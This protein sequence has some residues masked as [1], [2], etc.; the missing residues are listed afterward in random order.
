MDALKQLPIGPAIL[1]G[2]RFVVANGPCLRVLKL[3]DDGKDLVEIQ[4]SSTLVQGGNITS[5]SLMDDGIKAY[6]LIGGDNRMFI[7]ADA[8][9]CT[10]VETFYVKVKYTG[11]LV[12]KAVKP[13]EA[14]KNVISGD[15]E[16]F[17][18]DKFGD[19]L[20]LRV[21]DLRILSCT[22]R[23]R[24]LTH[25]LKN[26]KD[27][28]TF[29]IV[30]QMMDH[31]D[32]DVTTCSA[33]DTV[34]NKYINKAKDELKELTNVENE[35]DELTLELFSKGGNST[36]AT[37]VRVKL[38][39]FEG[40]NNLAAVADKDE[41][42][43]IVSANAVYNTLS[44]CL[45]HKKFVTDMQFFKIPNKEVVLLTSVGADNSLRLWNPLTGKCLF[46]LDDLDKIRD[47][48]V[49]SIMTTLALQ[50]V[51]DKDL[52]IYIGDTEG[53]IM[54]YSLNMMDDEGVKW[55]FGEA[56]LIKGFSNRCSIQ[57]FLITR[58]EDNTEGASLV[59][60]YLDGSI[61]S[62]NVKG[63]E[64]LSDKYSNFNPEIKFD[65]V[66]DNFLKHSYLKTTL[67]AE[68]RRNKRVSRARNEDDNVKKIKG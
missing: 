14:D 48:P 66:S 37:S 50:F 27:I 67:T 1:H 24:A 20:T 11:I 38:T 23:I 3:E 59:V 28:N 60:V 22:E 12:S 21:K 68:Q 57:N 52:Y 16:L 41:R 65:G 49:S 56:K 18:V 2:D 35:D 4:N 6:Y 5:L 7:I 40:A 15:T 30:K 25:L 62:L 32:I 19:F 34:M 46:I 58:R 13:A 43:M 17:A 39:R 10:V 8:S 45:G 42:I 9:S 33:K 44:Y 63:F 61:T 54:C 51:G 31:K 64:V 29:D 47:A 55:Y 26:P 36:M 53:Q